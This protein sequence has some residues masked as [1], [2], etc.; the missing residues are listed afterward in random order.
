VRSRPPSRKTSLR[1]LYVRLARGLGDRGRPAEA[2]P[3]LQQALLEESSGDA[4]DWRIHLDLATCLEAAGRPA[5]AFR[6]C[7]DAVLSG[8]ERCD[9]L[10]PRL[11]ALLRNGAA[12][13]YGDWTVGEWARAVA[14]SNPDAGPE[15]ELL[16][17]RVELFRGS[18]DAA[19]A[20]FEAACRARGGQQPA[21]AGRVLAPASLPDALRREPVTGSSHLVLAR[22]NHALGRHSEALAEVQAALETGI[23]AD[24]PNP[25]APALR[26]RAL[27]LQATGA[28]D[29][30][31]DA[32]YEAGCAFTMRAEFDTAVELLSRSLELRDDFPP[33]MWWLAD[34]LRVLAN[35][36]EVPV[37]DREKLDR[38]RSLWDRATAAQAPDE[39]FAW[40][41]LARARI[42]EGLATF[43]DY[44]PDG[45][46][47]AALFVERCLLLDQSNAS[48][49]ADLG[50]FHRS[51]GH[52]AL[53]LRVTEQAVDLDPGNVSVLEE[54]GAA[55]WEAGDE[56]AIE[57]LE[58]YGRAQPES[59]YWSAAMIGQLLGILGRP[60]AGLEHVEQ[61]TAMRP[62]DP[63]VREVRAQVY[64]L[65]GQVDKARAE[66]EW[67]WQATGTEGPLAAP[68]H[69]RFRGWAAYQLGRLDEAEAIYARLIE[70]P[71][72]DGFDKRVNL[73]YCALKRER[74]EEADRAFKASLLKLTSYRE[75]LD[76]QADLADIERAASSDSP[77]RAAVRRYRATLRRRSRPIRHHSTDESAPARELRVVLRAAANDGPATPRWLAA[78]AEVAR[79]NAH[80]SNW[81]DAVSAYETLARRDL[82]HEPRRIPEATRGLVA[83]LHQL[84]SARRDAGDVDAV[85]RAQGRLEELG[86]TVRARA[87]VEIALAHEARGEIDQAA[88]RCREAVESAEDHPS[89]MLALNALADVLLS[90]NDI[91]GA[92]SACEQGLRLATQVA[93]PEWQAHF[94]AFAGCVSAA[95]LDTDTAL[96]RFRRSMDLQKGTPT[97]NLT[98]CVVEVATSTRRSNL[99]SGQRRVL[100]EVMSLLA[101][102]LE[103]GDPNRS[104]LFAALW[105]LTRLKAGSASQ[106]P[107]TDVGT[108]ALPMVLEADQALFPLGEATPEVQRMLN[109]DIPALR[110]AIWDDM[111]VVAPPVHIY[112]SDLA[113]GAYV[114]WVHG[115][116]AAR[117]LVSV[118]TAQDGGY[119]RR[120]ALDA[121][122]CAALGV[123]GVRAPNPL[124]ARPGMWLTGPDDARR[125]AGAGVVVW[126]PYQ[127]ML[128][129]VDA[130]IRAD[131][132]A[133]LGVQEAAS[134]L[135]EWRMQAS[136][137]EQRLGDAV[138]G[139]H[140]GIVGFVRVLRSLVDEHVPIKALGAILSC[141]VQPDGR[142]ENPSEAVERARL[143][144]R[145]VLPG[146]DGSCQLIRLSP[147][148][149]ADLAAA[150]RDDRGRRFLGLS[151]AEAA[152]RRAAIQ[153]A[154][155]GR[156]GELALVVATQGLRR[157]VRRLL[158]PRLPDLPVLADAELVDRPAGSTIVELPAAL[159]ATA[160][161]APA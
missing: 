150:V 87:L 38:A 36:G 111:G 30:A 1:A 37:W 47:D 119:V 118:D 59:A 110:R 83:S 157:F 34:S 69:L 63:W 149:E 77:V 134:T 106:R 27:L 124:D 4:P 90:A 151:E 159:R 7:L 25:E 68:D 61:A 72:T 35:R 152:Q 108:A 39:D 20:H 22:V 48:A 116:T 112:A 74:V 161:V 71:S 98:R 139:D 92:V 49:L 78:A 66:S 158:R 135:Y 18:Y 17:G 62:T 123:Q 33:A 122:A 104:T 114:I 113:R 56:A 54:R 67:I 26:L 132:T 142:I 107:L 131:L 115:A 79:L 14:A 99:L 19:V 89:R 125:A 80:D 146:S 153:R 97:P 31:A 86:E 105:E 9:S 156:S 32:F 60:D 140:A 121:E 93:D 50:R 6:A 91:A 64:R 76:A 101:E 137:E 21:G 136:L 103:P 29:E 57:V 45:L 126:D 13:Q 10:M 73:A 55:L 44:Q 144:L 100:V 51:F 141:L 52:L 138:L 143:A 82:Q 15:V 88:A 85:V 109:E 154:V 94:E 81:A 133:F 46:W 117:G 16:L 23:T 3:L 155:A 5:D 40:A 147:E 53:A 24:E 12:E 160:E 145:A 127:L 8:P 130:V 75:I 129:H 95:A 58:A 41:H 96:A 28:S 42:A 84:S 2:I 128:R 65:A 11:H 70:D 120:Y 43:S 102:S 148:F